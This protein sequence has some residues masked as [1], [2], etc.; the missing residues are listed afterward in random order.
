MFPRERVVALLRENRPYL[1]AEY[2]V[3][4]IALFGSCAKDQL[5]EPSDIDLVV[6]F[7]RPIGLRFVDF[8]EHL[9]RLLGRRVDVLTPA[10]IQG[11][12][13]PRIARE[14]EQSMVYV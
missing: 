14:I 7:E 12:R 1:A 10:G 8:V 3:R 6:E 2:G 4:R 13:I 9:E 5:A 11:I